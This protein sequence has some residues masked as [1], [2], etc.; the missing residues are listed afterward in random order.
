[1][2]DSSESCSALQAYNA[3]AFLPAILTGEE[4]LEAEDIGCGLEGAENIGQ[5]GER[6]EVGLGDVAL[7]GMLPRLFGL[8]RELGR[9]CR[10][11]CSPS[12]L[13]RLCLGVRLW[14]LLPLLLL[15]LLLQLAVEET[16]CCKSAV[17][18]TLFLFSPFWECVG[19]WKRVRGL[20]LQ[21]GALLSALLLLDRLS[22][23]LAE[24]PAEF[25]TSLNIRS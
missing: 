3:R 2:K 15:L 13:V 9:I 11:S 12:L 1:M 19:V 14:L 23:M 21:D 8:S 10:L 25:G 6:G 17:L 18:T 24:P 7:V 5:E 4:S 20:S 16:G 22:C